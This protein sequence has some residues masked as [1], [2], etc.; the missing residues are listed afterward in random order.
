MILTQT[1]TDKLATDERTAIVSEAQM[2]P[3]D[4]DSNRYRMVGTV[5]LGTQ[6]FGWSIWDGQQMNRHFSLDTE[7][8]LATGPNI[9]QLAMV[10]VSDDTRHF[11]LKPNQ[12]SQ[13]LLQHLPFEHQFVCHNV[14]FDFW[15]LDR[16]LADTAAQQTRN[17]LWSAV[18]GNRVHD[19]MLLAGLV[20]LAE[21]DDDLMQSL[22]DVAKNY[23]GYELDKSD[24]FRT[25]YGETIGVDWSELDR[26]FFD[27]AISDAV[28]AYHAY[29]K[30]TAVAKRICDDQDANR[31]FG[32]L[33]EAIQVKAAIALDA[34]YRNGLSVDLQKSGELEK[35][36]LVDIKQ[37]A[38]QLMAECGEDVF[39][40]YVKTGELKLNKESQLP[41]MNQSVLVDQLESI[42]TVT[43]PKTESGKTTTSV[44]EFWGQ[45]RGDH[46]KIDAYCCYQ[47]L[48]KLRTFFAGLKDPKIH[49]KYR[50]FVRTGRTSCSGP[51][52]QQLPRGSQVR[53]VITAGPGNLLFIID[54]S[55]LELC[56][57]A[58]VCQQRYGFSKLGD[59]IKAGID[60]HAY[61]AAMFAG[62]S[63]EEFEGLSERK[64]L[65]QKAKAINFGFP[66]GLGSKTLVA[67]LKQSYGVDIT[68]DEAVTFR[69]MLTEQI[70]PELKTYLSSRQK[71]ETVVTP[72]GRIRANVS[73]T[74]ARNTPFQGLAADGCKL[75]MWELLKA[76]YRIAAFIHDEFAIQL[77]KL[78]DCTS[79][80]EDIES[81]CIE[82]MQRLTGDI[83]ITT[84]Y[85]L[86]YRWHKDATAC[87]SD[88]GQ[89]VEWQPLANADML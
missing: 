76:G 85:A 61:T 28:A 44:N 75:A 4:F 3:Q 13:F 48:N 15:V 70:F 8:T 71:R 7:T 51:N 22:A 14:A 69:K 84:E 11:I 89:L 79:A 82:S 74:Q 10:S 24:P 52:L 35:Q 16:Y 37:A 73:Y 87:F 81:I 46:P 29:C 17:W 34:I 18:E 59:V 83:P 60:P 47:E 43:P 1:T 36:V 25:R 66:G 49:P 23:C 80:A 31:Q 20:S 9:P 65:R 64:E 5:K 56:T 53:D 50:T 86:T 12:V 21:E 55:A 39:H 67:Y 72:T 27:Y 77:S 6:T 2:L 42:A 78:D 68:K 38:D 63:L 30:L 62:V 57:L 41:K 54:Y 26:G 19:T 45:F 58:A 88:E 40:R 32:F 33:T